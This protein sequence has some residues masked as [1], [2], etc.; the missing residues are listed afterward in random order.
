MH[1]IKRFPGAAELLILDRTEA[2]AQLSSAPLHSPASVEAAAA[3]LRAQGFPA[4]LITEDNGADYAATEH[5]SGWLGPLP[6][7]HSVLAATAAS[8]LADGF[9]PIEAIILGKMA[10]HQAHQHGHTHDFALDSAN[11]PGFSVPGAYWDSN[12]RFAPLQNP[13]LGLYAVLDSAAWIERVLAAGVRTVQLRIKESD[14]PRLRDEIR[15]SIAA[16]RRAGAQLFINDHWQIALEEGA[17][18]VHLGQEDLAHADLSALARAGLRLGLSTHAYWEVCRAWALH[19]SYIACGPIHAT[20]SKDMPW[21]PQ[22]NGNLAY[23]SALLSQSGQL[24][25]VGIAGMDAQRVK[26]AAQCGAAG[27][28]VISAITRARN[29]ELAI[30]QLQQAFASGKTTSHWPVPALAQSTLSQ[31]PLH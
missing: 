11:L 18:G 30:G 4:I 22:G 19:P 12:L 6:G 20:Q 24:P 25:V 13:D 10:S 31:T 29:P 3:T 17:Y 23:W 9:V 2:A 5:A 8:A 14:A 27:A 21:T 7:T 16:A 28:A 26:E 1:K 15:Q